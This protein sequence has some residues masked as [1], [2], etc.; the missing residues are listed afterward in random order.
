ME[1]Q[2][3][4]NQTRREFLK[5]SALLAGAIV[6]PEFSTGCASLS[7]IDR[8]SIDYGRDIIL[9]NC[10][11]VD[12]K[13]GTIRTGAS[14]R[15]SHGKVASVG[16]RIDSASQNFDVFELDGRFVIPGLINAHCHSTMTGT[17]SFNPMKEVTLRLHCSL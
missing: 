17:A 16:N 10:S 11:L 15:I 7:H 14:L 12:P 6:L 3:N 13:N 9:N 2:F 1:E 5:K 4:T 8:L